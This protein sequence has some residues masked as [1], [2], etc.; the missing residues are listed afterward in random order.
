MSTQKFSFEEREAIWLAYDKKCMYTSEPLDIDNFHIDHIIPEEYAKKQDEFEQLKIDL[1]L[2][3]CFDMFG[4]ENLAPCKPG[5]N[6]RKNSSL[7]EKNAIIYYL[8]VAKR[9]KEMIVSAL[10][11]IISRNKKGQATIRLIQ[12]LECGLLSKEDVSGILDKHG[13]SPQEIFTLL[14]ELEFEESGNVHSVTKEKIDDLLTLKIHLGGR[15][16][17]HGLDL[18]SEEFGEIH[19]ATCIEYDQAIARGYFPKSNFDIMLSISF[20]HQCGLLKA[21]KKACTPS[22]SYVS[23][24]RRGIV[25]LNILPFSFFPNVGEQGAEYSGSETYQD[26]IRNG[27]LFIRSVNQNSIIIEEAEGMGQFLVEVV[28]ADFN[29]DGMEEILLYECC[30]A[31][32]GTLI[33]GGVRVITRTSEDSL[34]EVVEI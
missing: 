28:R 13:E 34:F 8:G 32:H 5:V 24:P 26:K 6:L 2:D 14:K 16:H 27:E 9:K 33:Y 29:D 12:Y 7:F 15:D 23:S 22:A 30:Y 17:I 20:E 11:K 10:G 21:L 4:Y 18:W 25:D 19:V 3:A 31:T 1:C